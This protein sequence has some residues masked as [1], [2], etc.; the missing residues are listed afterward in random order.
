[1]GVSA[2]GRPRRE[3]MGPCKAYGTHVTRRISPIGPISPI[4]K[5]AFIPIMHVDAETRLLAPRF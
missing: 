1:M 2:C 3:Q 5:Q 4:R